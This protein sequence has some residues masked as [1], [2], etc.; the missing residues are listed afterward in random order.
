MPL[1]AAVQASQPSN[2]SV[3]GGSGNLNP[4]PPKKMK[5]DSSDP[6]TCPTATVSLSLPTLPT[7]ALPMVSTPGANFPGGI[8]LTISNGV[9]NVK[10]AQ[11]QPSMQPMQL[12]VRTSQ[13]V[14]PTSVAMVKGQF[15]TTNSAGQISSQMTTLP[16]GISITQ[17]P[18]KLAN[19]S[20]IRTPT[21]Y[22]AQNQS[23]QSGAAITVRP[24]SMATQRAPIS[25]QA[26]QAAVQ[27]KM[28]L[29]GDVSMSQTSPSHIAPQTA[30]VIQLPGQPT[31]QI[32]MQVQGQGQQH[33]QPHPQSQMKVQTAVTQKSLI[34][35]ATTTRKQIK[36]PILNP[37]KIMKQPQVQV[38]QPGPPSP[39]QTSALLLPKGK[40]QLQN[41]GR[42]QAVSSPSQAVLASPKSHI[43]I[44]PATTLS[45]AQGPVQL[46][47]PPL[48]TAQPRPQGQSQIQSN[49]IQFP[50]GSQ[51][52]VQQNSLPLRA[53]L[54]VPATTSRTTLQGQELS[55]FPQSPRTTLSSQESSLHFRDL[56]SNTSVSIISS[57]K[58]H[59]TSLSDKQ[60]LPTMMGQIRPQLQVQFQN[61]AASPLMV[62]PQIRIQNAASPNS[63]IDSQTPTHVQINLQD[64]PGTTSATP[65]P[66]PQTPPVELQPIT[67]NQSIAA[68]PEKSSESTPQ[69][70]S[71]YNP[72]ATASS[73]IPVESISEEDIVKSKVELSEIPV[74]KV[75][76]T[77]EHDCTDRKKDVT[78]KHDVANQKKDVTEKHDG[79]DKKMDNVEEKHDDSNQKED[80][81][82]DVVKETQSKCNDKEP[83]QE[84]KKGSNVLTEEVKDILSEET[85]T[86]QE[87][88]EPSVK[89]KPE[90]I[91]EIQTETQLESK[92]SIKIE[93]DGKC[94][95]KEKEENNKKEEKPVKDL[96][97][98]V[99]RED[100]GDGEGPD[101]DPADI[102]EWED[103]IGTL[104][105]SDLKFKLNEFGC[106]ELTDDLTC[107]ETLDVSNDS[108]D[109]TSGPVTNSGDADTKVASIEIKKEKLDESDE[110]CQCE[111]CGEHGFSSE[112]CKDGRFCSQTC[113]GAFDSK[114]MRG[115]K[116]HSLV[117]KMVLGL[118]KKRRKLLMSKIAV[119]DEDSGTLT[120]CKR[121][122][123]FSWPKYLE[124][125]NATAAT[126]RMF[127][128]AYPGTKNA[129][130]V[131]MKIEGIDPK[132]PSLYCVL[133]VA[134][135]MG[136][137]L[138]LHFD[139]YSECYDFWT[140]ADSPFIFPVG[141]C[142][143]N[144]KTL[145][146]P[147]GF[148]VDDFSWANYMKISKATAAPKN[149]FLNLPVQSVT[150]NAIRPG[151]K[152]EAV[153][154]KNNCLTCVATVPDT[155][156][157]KLLVHFDGWEDIYDYWCDGTSPYVHPVGWCQANGEPLSPPFDWDASTFSWSTY[158]S[159]TKSAGVPA[160]ALKPRSPMGFEAGVK[161]EV[162]DKRNPILIRVATIVEVDEFRVK[163]HFD[164]WADSY[165][166]W[167][168]DDC[169]DIHP[170]GWCARTGHYI[171]PPVVPSDFVSSPGQGGCPTPGCKGIGHI[172][173]AKYTGH[174]SHFGCPYSQLNMNKETTLQDRLGSTRSEEG[175][176]STSPPPFGAPRIYKPGE[177]SPS[178]EIKKCPTAGCDGSGHVTGKFTAHHRVSG[179]PLVDRNPIP[180]APDPKLK[181]S[182]A[183]EIRPKSTRGR[184]PR[185][186]YLNMGSR[187]LYPPQKNSKDVDRRGDLPEH[188]QYLHQG[189]HQSV[190]MSAMAPNPNK[191]L[192]L[193]WEQH[194]K[195]LPGVDK[196]RGGDV[197]AWSIERVASFIK[198]LPGCEEQ[199][200][201]F[202][203]EQID[204]EA[205]LLLNQ[206]DIVKILN[207]K[208]G[209][210][211][212]I[213]NSVLMFK[214]SVES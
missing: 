1:I 139:G 74:V 179:C 174:H 60:T 186:Y 128:E 153:D 133:T 94:G 45:S 85:I 58:E 131:G 204:G 114:R 125:E 22:L 134:E 39:G 69:M 43:Q 89:L 170:P 117:S 121:S 214:N 2:M 138:R 206:T 148:S 166:Y 4:P 64:I 29:A 189:I 26:I 196:I 36:L 8:S 46:N 112:F 25:V 142:E 24:I 51:V 65:N 126:A 185:S 91:N 47:S 38:I 99:K 84:V 109:V 172:K 59:D 212:K 23:L 150:P 21:A 101:F 76:E 140:N 28:T 93:N 116:K 152:L 198:S 71:V 32:Q 164:G 167:V 70:I 80:N 157:D 92:T 34:T 100:S 137:R 10:P 130:K 56:L 110:I 13:G 160:R 67:L 127:K 129:F 178:P 66:T 183:L 82:T 86:L 105:G 199:A 79:T 194:S 41:Q 48:N 95:V 191:D 201:V 141:F 104:P 119:R 77:R 103:G 98:E 106:I 15:V 53:Q 124:D 20:T 19:S 149:L 173:G 81:V 18:F 213:Y 83:E 49:I 168:D 132:H 78:E 40:L 143:K 175:Q 211:L 120:T 54:P 27:P 9:I 144:G 203:D 88:V 207:I 165:D 161:V 163:I 50:I 182:T 108:D 111:N 35:G 3:P 177:I 159:T 180:P 176:Q 97:T 57:P 136:F 171:S 75:D 192:S 12:G 190:F 62:R 145:Q 33:L 6:P 155:L 5:T 208:L 44:Q 158:L 202:K 72:V 31:P 61:K 169:P 42:L 122:K 187:G 102:M 96:K 68:V 162:V 205:F 193:C 63:S 87:S 188:N 115:V 156:G 113:V 135:I 30:Q 55:P 146:P 195:L 11:V 151:M 154:K 181:T 147:K 37:A 197:S 118:K 200:K 52:L 7:T 209:P 90:N 16:A 184:K 107:P 210:A 73:D 14:I 123:S 17:G